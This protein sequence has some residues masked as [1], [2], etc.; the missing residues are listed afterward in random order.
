MCLFFFVLACEESLLTLFVLI[1]SC[2]RA[3]CGVHTTQP[4]FSVTVSVLSIV[5]GA[6]FFNEISGFSTQQLVFFPAGVLVTLCGVY[7]LSQREVDAVVAVI[8]RKRTL[9][10]RPVLRTVSVTPAPVAAAISE[11]A[12]SLSSPVEQGGA[13]PATTPGARKITVWRDTGRGKYTLVDEIVDSAAIVTLGNDEA[14]DD[15]S[16]TV[17]APVTPS[18]RAS[19]VRG[20]TST[21]SKWKRRKHSTASVH[22]VAWWEWEEVGEQEVR[23]RVCVAVGHTSKHDV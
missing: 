1:V 14:A 11:A 18:N 8:A 10:R 6:V 15:G 3:Y 16:G 13:L 2:L 17:A 21:A 7:L 4:M 9:R 12:A 20:A 5:T 22:E 19:V 23:A